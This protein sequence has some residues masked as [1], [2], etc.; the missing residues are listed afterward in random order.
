M[1]WHGHNTMPQGGPVA[2]IWEGFPVDALGVVATIAHRW[3]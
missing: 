2:A 3:L 1:G